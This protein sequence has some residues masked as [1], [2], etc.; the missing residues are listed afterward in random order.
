[1]S[2]DATIGYGGGIFDESATVEFKNTILWNNTA[3]KGGD[4]IYNS[5]GFTSTVLHSDVQGGW[6][7]TGNINSD[8][9]FA[10]GGY[11]LTAS[12]P[13]ADEWR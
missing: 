9:L 11:K 1:M 10:S 4:Q 2:N 8:P 6:T 7:G 13:W 5:S 3:I 12:S